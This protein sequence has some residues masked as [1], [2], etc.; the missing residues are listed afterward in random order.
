MALG[1]TLGVLVAVRQATCNPSREAIRDGAAR[2][3]VNEYVFTAADQAYV[4]TPAGFSKSGIA[5][6]ASGGD[7]GRIKIVVRDGATGKL[8]CCRINVVGADGNYYQSAENRLT[9]FGLTTDHRGYQHYPGKLPRGNIP[10]GP[11]RYFGRYFYS[12]GESTVAVP[13]GP[14]RIEVWKGFE[15]EPA[16]LGTRVE[17]GQEQTA[18]LTLMRTLPMAKQGYYSGDPHLHFRRQTPE[19][20]E[21]ILDLME[22]EDIRFGA[23]LSYNDP[24]GP[25]TATMRHQAAPQL[26]GLGTSSIRSRG[27]YHILSG[28]EYRST[29]Y[30][31]LN[32]FL[33]DGMVLPDQ[34]I[35]ADDWPPYGRIGEEVQKIG[36]YVFHAH[37]GFAQSIYADFV[38]GHVNGVELLQFATYY[39]LGLE[40]W[41]HILNIGYR[42]PATG[43][44]DYPWSRMLGDSK[45]YVQIEGEPAF[46]NWLQGAAEGRSF[47][48]TGPM[49][50]LEVDGQKP[51]ARIDRSG[52]GP[53]RVTARI[54]VRSEVSRV[55]DVQLVV[56]GELIEAMAVP[57]GQT[58]KSWVTLERNVE[59]SES[60]WLAARAFGAA[61]SG[62]PDS[63][64]HTNPVFVYLNGK[65][66]Y[67][68][69]SLDHLVACIDRQISF[70]KSR[71]FERKEHKA[72]VLAYF[73]RSRDILMT[74]RAN[75]GTPADGGPLQITA[76][77]QSSLESPGAAVHS[78]E[79]LAEFLQPIPP[80]SPD[81]AIKTFE[82]VDGFR[83]ELVAHEPLVCDPVA[84]EFDENGQLYVC[85]MRDY[86]YRPKA[87][88]RPLGTVRLLR[89]TNEDGTFE[90]SHVFA[91]GLLWPTGVVPWKGGVYVAAA[92]DIWYLKDV[93]G[94]FRADV[95]TKVFTGFGTQNQQ[96]MLNNLKYGPDHKIY[97]STGPNG[98]TIRP[99]G[100]EN[101]KAISVAGRDFRFN[102]RTLQF[103]TITGTVQF[104]NAFDD[105][106]NRFVCSQAQPLLHVVLPQH[107]LA[108]NP[109]L[110]VPQAI[111]NL[112]PA[113]V[114][115]F[116]I[117]PTERWR[118]IRSN[119]LI[120]YN[121]RAS[122]A[123]GVSHH[124]VDAAAG[125][126]I[127][128]G[129]AYP[130]SYY[131]NVFVA[132]AQNNLVH[133]RILTP[134]GPSFTS[135]RADE[136]TEFVRSSDNWFRPV[137]F[138]NAPDGT[139]FVLDMSREIIESIHI[140]SDVVKHLD[141]KNG[142]DQ[143]RI[144][145]LAP[146]RF[147][148][149]PPPQLGKATT[150][151]LV[152]TLE[153]PNGWW[154]DTAHRLIFE[155]QDR[156]VVA[157]LRSMFAESEAPQARL[158]ALRS[159][160][161]LSSLSDDDIS[162][163]LSDSAPQVREHAIQLS[164]PRLGS[165]PR[166]LEKVL[167][168]VD[169]PDARVIFQLAFTIGEIKDE[170][171]VS[172]LARIARKHAVDPWIRSA[173]LSSAAETADEL[174]IE[175]VAG[176]NF[177]SMRY[178]A[179]FLAQLAQLVGAQ[180]QSDDIARVLAAIAKHGGVS[181]SSGF[182][183]A[184]TVALG[185]GIKRSGGVLPDPTT[186][187]AAAA[188]FLSALTSSAEQTATD[189]SAALRK[190]CDAI[191]FLGC[192]QFAKSQ[193]A[194]SKLLDPSQPEELQLAA[195]DAVADYSNAHVGS[196]VIEEWSR[197]VPAVRTRAI[198]V[199]LSRDEWT[200]TYLA[201]VDRGDATVAE[202]GAA[203]RAQLL[204][205]PNDSIRRDANKL[206]SQS[207]RA[208]V[209]A[210]YRSILTKPGDVS[211]G[212]DVFK[213]E[214]AQCHRVGNDGHDVGPDLA[215]SP[216]RD[217]ESLLIN[218]LDPN[219]YVDPAYIQYIIIDASG[220]TFTG[221]VVAQ[222]ATSVTLNSGQGLHDTIL[223][224]NID[225]FVSTGM[226]LMPE[227]LE[228]KIFKEEMAHLIAFLTAAG[229]PVTESPRLYGGTQ[230]GLIEPK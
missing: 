230:P 130:P 49:L 140:P 15:Y 196:L 14:V 82:T 118:Q 22:A 66:P 10:V 19:D 65:A 126:T 216:S 40:D 72:E 192:I 28:Q 223:R 98:G 229:G 173:V 221:K 116:R 96:A 144:Y 117:S 211:R 180:R 147:R 222:T 60:A 97:G 141:L 80:K 100:D 197:Y 6:R 88:N 138:I 220:R 207:P 190:R 139:L 206:F 145:R 42:F 213:R 34:A 201:A 20:D 170:R 186:L 113:P 142:R 59:L 166:L 205:H 187:P 164:E 159:L 214:C 125:V 83:M 8:V 77:P 193:S 48:T 23:I 122:T 87:G 163:A 93:D 158:L 209:V 79:V 36:G 133:R 110:S 162:Q 119:R 68:H 57:V 128:R 102:P 172:L 137:N 184:A 179:E 200:E 212:K 165:S 143:G 37:G 103:E 135:R 21:L 185:T 91:D 160:E 94:D 33:R 44:C 92:P 107:Y 228:V 70:H 171:A 29:T 58:T 35:N 131:G 109:H 27:E 168:Q 151:Q 95:R 217:P 5:I 174:F 18:E 101:G 90:E 26:R 152:D 195:L 54:R 124:V 189:S 148:A 204:E 134:D 121:V 51:G 203:G 45:T 55:T 183:H 56:N 210:D 218:I 43:A 155:R 62:A 153:N 161:G 74:I 16:T 224:T 115:I 219:R 177:V 154:R 146:P 188:Q 181:S 67:Q 215:S 81:E 132:D 63:E 208:A 25:Y 76:Q 176:E 199:L 157:R 12:L 7:T 112:A 17:A 194:F 9:P 104:G 191:E 47:F 105:L 4:F 73:E 1:A 127:Y 39:G 85:E 71:D 120:A 13:A 99:G 89:D 149:T 225:Q 114:P 61:P 175:L 50:L 75:G 129:A 156:S 38:Q 111:K 41:Y 24:P 32:L 226:S 78:E 123:D 2:K 64:S 52:K 30:G 150:A 136:H 53:H 227:G 11:I 46:A 169:D 69:A 198:Q 178:G 202:I 108:R 84:A 3:Y 182:Q 106:G 31:H 167:A 86:P